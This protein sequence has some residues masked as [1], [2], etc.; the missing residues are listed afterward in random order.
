M[1]QFVMP[2]V[3]IDDFVFGVSAVGA[4]GAESLV[5]AYVNPPR[6]ETAVKVK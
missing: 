3:S 1:T 4:D 6:V 5:A 2:D